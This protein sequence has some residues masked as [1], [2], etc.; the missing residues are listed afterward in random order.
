MRGKKKSGKKQ[1]GKK[2]KTQVSILKRQCCIQTS[3]VGVYQNV[4]VVIII[5]VVTLAISSEN[6]Y[7]M[8]RRTLMYL[9]K[10]RN[11]SSVGAT[12]AGDASVLRV[13][14]QSTC[15]RKGVGEY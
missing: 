14:A 8:R 2:K 10:D 12:E 9:R 13:I 4:I 1:S 11:C 7:S 15:G 6:L 3:Q 5:V